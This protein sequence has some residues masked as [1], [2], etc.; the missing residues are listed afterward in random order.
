MSQEAELKAAYADLVSQIEKIAYLEGQ[1]GI[2]V[3]W[4]VLVA[5]QD[6][7]EEGVGVTAVGY[8]LPPDRSMPWHRVLGLIDFAKTMIRKEILTPDDDS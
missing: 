3:D 7:D 4:T 5:T 6:F 8:L 1:K 2:I